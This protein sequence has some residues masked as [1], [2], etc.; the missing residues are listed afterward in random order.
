MKK[1]PLNTINR[2]QIL[3]SESEQQDFFKLQKVS[4]KKVLELWFLTANSIDPFVTFCKSQSCIVSYNGTWKE[5]KLESNFLFNKKF[6]KFLSLKEKNY[7]LNNII[8]FVLLVQIKTKEKDVFYRFIEHSN[9][10]P[11]WTFLRIITHQ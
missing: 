10:S 6:R 4:T 7:L 1:N 2:R 3:S 11:H 9:L 5:Y 8:L